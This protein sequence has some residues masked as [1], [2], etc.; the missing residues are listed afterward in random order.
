M[1]NVTLTPTGLD[2]NLIGIEAV[3]AAGTELEREA[4]RL[5]A[6]QDDLVA[7]DEE[8]VEREDA[9]LMPSQTVYT[10][11]KPRVPGINAED[12]EDWKYRLVCWESDLA[13]RDL[14]ATTLEEYGD[15]EDCEDCE[16]DDDIVI[17]WI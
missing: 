2:I 5:E 7:Q 15:M 1:L 9:L 13:A 10:A 14:H 11:M 8:M 3:S 16:D 6:W 17:A 12:L 4:Q